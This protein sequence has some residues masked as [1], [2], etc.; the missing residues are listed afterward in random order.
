M[1]A[2][3]KSHRT[4]A[5]TILSVFLIAML[6]DAGAQP[7]R[8]RHYTTPLWTSD[9]EFTSIAA[10]RIMSDGRSLIAD[11]G[12]TSLVLLNVVGRE[13]GRVHQVGSG[14]NEFRS[15]Q[16]LLEWSADSSLLVDASQS[17]VLVISPSG[18]AVRQESV[19]SAIAP[20]IGRKVTIDGDGNF[21]VLSEYKFDR[22]VRTVELL[23]WR[24]AAGAIDTIATMLAQRELSFIGRNRQGIDVPMTRVIP[25]TPSDDW[26]TFPSGTVAIVRSN[27]FAVEVF[28]RRGVVSRS[29]DVPQRRTK[30][31]SD[32]LKGYSSRLSAEAPKVKPPFVASEVIGGTDGQVWIRRT[33]ECDVNTSLYANVDLRTGRV[34][35]VS[36]VGKRYLMAATATRMLVVSFDSEGVQS[37]EMFA[38]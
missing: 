12:E 24:R 19:P 26:I 10:A 1:F 25:F 16:V 9:V 23:S 29:L 6:R 34:S 11:G 5:V 22:R 21:Y 35:E 4:A 8:P 15:V 32:E 31:C 2:S 14:P 30:V 18:R 7:V 36:F 27:P 17:R 20:M 37:V 3:S 38:R 33:V 13:T 28:G